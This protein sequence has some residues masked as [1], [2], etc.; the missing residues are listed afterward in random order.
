[1]SVLTHP[2]LFWFDL[3]LVPLDDRLASD[4]RPSKA[5]RSGNLQLVEVLLQNGAN[6]SV[7]NRNGKTPLDEAQM[8]QV[9]AS[10]AGPCNNG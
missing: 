9:L 6:P 3:Q 4:V 7:R 5:V 8:L 1:M 10:R 2:P